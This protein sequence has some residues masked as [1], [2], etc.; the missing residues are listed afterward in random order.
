MNKYN[1]MNIEFNMDNMIDVFV[2]LKKWIDKPINTQNI[3]VEQQRAR[4]LGVINIYRRFGN[5]ISANILG[6]WFRDWADM[7]MA[8]SFAMV[9]IKSFTE[10]T[11]EEID[12][13]FESYF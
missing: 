13:N 8:N 1:V 2:H 7:Q 5:V 9:R 10:S 11:K 4:N 12:G 6:I 3:E